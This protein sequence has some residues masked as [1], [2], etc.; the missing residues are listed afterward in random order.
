MAKLAMEYC[1]TLV[2]AAKEGVR[3]VLQQGE[4]DELHEVHGEVGQHGDGGRIVGCCKKLIGRHPLSRVPQ[5]ALSLATSMAIALHTPIITMSRP[6]LLLRLLLSAPLATSAVGPF[7]ITFAGKAAQ[8]VTGRA[9][10][11]I[12]TD[13]TSEPR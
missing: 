4:R 7:T 9:F 8:N 6:T 2:E 13:L 3:V 1:T 5:L 11:F 12:S 10:L